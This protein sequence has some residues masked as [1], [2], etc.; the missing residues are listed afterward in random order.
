MLRTVLS[1]GEI[2]NLLVRCALF[3]K[4]LNAEE[5]SR[6]IIDCLQG[7]LGINLRDWRTAMCDRAMTNKYSLKKLKHK[8]QMLLFLI[9]F[10]F[11]ILLVT[12]EMNR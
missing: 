7:R 12:V 4:H 8:L 2:F 1:N 6:H 3:I 10:V 5:L 11:P 9:S